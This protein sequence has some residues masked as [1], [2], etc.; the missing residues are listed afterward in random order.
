MSK[1]TIYNS[2]DDL[3][4]ITIDDSKCTFTL[5]PPS[6]FINNSTVIYNNSNG[7]NFAT[8]SYNDS[9]NN[10]NIKTDSEGIIV[11]SIID[12]IKIETDNAT[13]PTNDFQIIY[14]NSKGLSHTMLSY[15][16]SI[17]VKNNGNK[18]S[19]TS[20]SGSYIEFES[21]NSNFEITMGEEI[22][23]SSN[24]MTITE[25]TVKEFSVSPLILNNQCSHLDNISINADTIFNNLYANGKVYSINISKGK[26]FEQTGNDLF[27][28]ELRLD[29]KATIKF[30]HY[31]NNYKFV[32]PYQTNAQSI[33]TL[34]DYYNNKTGYYEYDH[35]TS[36]KFLN[37]SVLALGDILSSQ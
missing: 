34:E 14:D 22:S 24:G 16:N 27:I 15:N 37:S 5:T 32:N 28:D 21:H 23:V 8:I 10:I 36:F 7:L 11:N 3:G 13:I 20:G 2:N 1:L 26:Q 29:S 9:G 31:G 17:V 19:I 25:L 12:D 33:N 18:V 30:T 4:P 35:L 6:C